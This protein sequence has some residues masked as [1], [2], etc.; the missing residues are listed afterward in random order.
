[1]TQLFSYSTRFILDKNYFI[2][3]FEQSKSIDYSWQAY[4]KAIFFSTFG[5]LLV[6]FTPINT[7]AAWFLF[8]LGIIDALGVYYQ[9]PWWVTRQMLSRASGSEVTL[10]LNEQSIISHSF[11]IDETILWADISLLD[12]TAKGWI[13]Q[14]A[15]GKNY[16]SSSF[17]DDAA[18]E[19][20]MQKLPTFSVD[21]HDSKNV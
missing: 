9:K 20:L 5:A 16:I 18:N 14:H 6:L 12:K 10:T 11:Y 3:C 17:L 19:F 2:E 13:V 7:Y 15:K 21:A 4:F 8:T 1:M